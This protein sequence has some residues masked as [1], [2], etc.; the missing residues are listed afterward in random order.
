[1]AKASLKAEWRQKCCVN[2]R[3]TRSPLKIDERIFEQETEETEILVFR[4]L[5]S[6]LHPVNPVNPVILSPCFFG[7]ELWACHEKTDT[8][9]V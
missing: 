5:F 6:L 8:E 3:K 1:L 7:N 9:I 4:S 2:L